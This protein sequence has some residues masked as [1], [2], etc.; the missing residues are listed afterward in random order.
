MWVISYM[1]RGALADGFGWT[2]PLL[3]RNAKEKHLWKT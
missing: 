2:L 1:K 3:S